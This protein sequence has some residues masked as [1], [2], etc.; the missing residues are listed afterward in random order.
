MTTTQKKY[1]TAQQIPDILE[2]F[3]IDFKYKAGTYS[4]ACPVHNG[5]NATAC[6]IFEGR[7]DIPNWQCWTHQCQNTYGK[8]LYGFIRGV[9][10]ARGGEEVDFKAVNNFLRNKNLD[11]FVSIEKTPANQQKILTRALSV[12]T[13]KVTKNIDRDYIRKNLVC[14]SPYFLG[15]NFSAEIL[16]MFDVGDSHQSGRMMHERAVVPVY[17]IDGSYAGCCG[18]TI[19]GHKD[20]WIY[21]FNK[22]N[23]LY[24]L[25][26]SLEHIQKSGWAVIVEGNPD[27]WEI[28]SHGFRNSVAIMGTAFTDEQ[29]LLLE[30]SGALNLLIFTDMDSAGRNCADSIVK[31]CGRRFNYYVP[32]YG[33][34]DPGELGVEVKNILGNYIDLEKL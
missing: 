31:K 15:R 34:K 23:F 26:L 9:L 27:L 20:K 1:L 33:A 4:F 25:N 8:G 29:L 3:K 13:N 22:G 5:D 6:T 19:V 21:S 16:D 14:P 18:R 17:D 2:S 30:Q 32:E 24:G 12:G 7:H 28:F 11:F 10:S